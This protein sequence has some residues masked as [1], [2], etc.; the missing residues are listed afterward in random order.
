MPI[1]N[2]PKRVIEKK[3]DDATIKEPAVEKK[4]AIVPISLAP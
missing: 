2:R 3:G 4:R 1:I